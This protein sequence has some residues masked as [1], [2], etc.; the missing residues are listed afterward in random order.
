MCECEV[1]FFPKIKEKFGTSDLKEWPVTMGMNEKGWMDDVEFR[2][3][4]KTSL[5]HYSLTGMM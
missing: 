1:A 2:Q 3:Y 5:F 4:F